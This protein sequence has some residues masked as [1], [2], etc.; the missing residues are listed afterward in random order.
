MSSTLHKIPVIETR[1]VHCTYHIWAESE[2]EALK[3]ARA[4]DYDDLADDPEYLTVL[5]RKVGEVTINTT[6]PRMEEVVAKQF[7]R[8]ADAALPRK[9]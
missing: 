1:E 3:R 5:S 7:E 9:I 8:P 6:Q 2:E 4:G